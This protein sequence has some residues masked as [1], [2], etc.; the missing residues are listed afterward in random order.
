VDQQTYVDCPVEK[1]ITATA[2]DTSFDV[3]AKSKSGARF[4]VTKEA[5]GA[6]SRTCRPAGEGGCKAGGK[7]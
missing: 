4:T 3:T 2:D 1:G 5:S 7:W 6:L